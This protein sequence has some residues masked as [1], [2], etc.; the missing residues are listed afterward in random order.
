MPPPPPLRREFPIVSRLAIDRPTPPHVGERGRREASHGGSV[1]GGG[2]SLFSR[3]GRRGGPRREHHRA[4]PGAAVAAGRDP[5]HRGAARARGRQVTLKQ[6]TQWPTVV[7]GLPLPDGAE[8]AT[9]KGA[10]ALV[11]L[12]DGSAI[13]LRGDSQVALG[14]TGVELGK[15]EIWLD[16]PA[17]ERGGLTHKLARSRSR[18]PT[19][20]SR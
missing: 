14:R 4:G 3:R 12:S 13:F 19:R 6:G 17:S 8:L 1:L 15:G 9:G 18:P 7:S 2:L 5:Q 11:R 10:R 16:A 20:A